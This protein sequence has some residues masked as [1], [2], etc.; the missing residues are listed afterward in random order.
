MPYKLEKTIIFPHVPKTGGTTIQD[1]LKETDLRVYHDSDA[2]PGKSRWVR[3][4][5]AR[6][7]LECSFLDFSPFDLVYGHFP[8][9]R[10]DS[11]RYAHVA[12][13]RDP[14]DRAIS[15][16]LYAIWRY[17]NRPNLAAEQR[18]NLKAV[19]E[20]EVDFLEFIRQHR[21]NKFYK[22]FLGY[23]DKSRFILIGDTSRYG[24]FIGQLNELLGTSFTASVQRRKREDT[25]FALSAE[26]EKAARKYL[27]DE[28]AWYEAF[29]S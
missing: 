1:Q 23:W 2:V 29:V 26:E 27:A 11:D 24:E 10:Y 6:R 5:V 21:M 25:A 28:C 14:V 22:Q 20:G 4:N 3:D 17:R 16:Y 18:A 8:V 12:L 13:V 19:G 7:N 9:E 15:H